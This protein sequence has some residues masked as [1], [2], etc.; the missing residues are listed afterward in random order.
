MLWQGLASMLRWTGGTSPSAT[1][2]LVGSSRDGVRVRL[3]IC[4]STY[5]TV[6]F[7]MMNSHNVQ[8]NLCHTE[9]TGMLYN[10]TKQAPLLARHIG[11]TYLR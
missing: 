8:Y 9:V 4:E 10:S 11:N 3:N 7:F 1:D 5:C 6:S 2:A